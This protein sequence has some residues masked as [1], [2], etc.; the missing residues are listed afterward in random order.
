MAKKQRTNILVNI[1]IS[2][3]RQETD[4]SFMIVKRKLNKEKLYKLKSLLKPLLLDTHRS[5][6]LK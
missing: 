3:S 1:S 2:I 5:N 6:R 4:I